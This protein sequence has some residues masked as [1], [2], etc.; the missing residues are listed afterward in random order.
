MTEYDPSDQDELIAAYLDGEATAAERANVE[1]DP[2]LVERATMLREV[3][4]MVAEPVMAPP[5]DVKRAHIAAALAASA[6][7]PNVTALATRRKRTQLRTLATIAAVVIAIL[8]V[9]IA[10]LSSVGDDDDDTATAVSDGS[11]LSTEG[12]P[13]LAEGLLED[14]E[15]GDA[16][17]SPDEGGGRAFDAD[18]G[19]ASGD[20][21]AASEPESE[22][23]PAAEE[24]APAA[25]PAPAASADNDD[26]GERAATKRFDPPGPTGPVALSRSLREAVATDLLDSDAETDLSDADDLLCAAE[27]DD[28]LADEFAQLGPDFVSGVVT[29]NGQTVEYV[30]DIGDEI[31]IAVFDQTCAPTIGSLP[32]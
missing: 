10:L 19:A 21:E 24:A 26:E 18:D 23:E 15:S 14:D 7:A 1:G 30:A 17:L 8:A 29:I 32:G 13:A 28:L 27:I 31:T 3:A 20:G 9:P 5:P 12:Q 22:E 4:D 11:A 6:T 2:N 25:T 16:A